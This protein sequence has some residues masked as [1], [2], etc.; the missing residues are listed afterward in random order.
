[1]IILTHLVEYYYKETQQSSNVQT[2]MIIFLKLSDSELI[3]RS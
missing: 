2:E 1:M 3:Q